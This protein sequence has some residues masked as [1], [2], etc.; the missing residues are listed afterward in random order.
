[1]DQR[2]GKSKAKRAVANDG[3]TD[4]M[5]EDTFADDAPTDH[6]LDDA[7]E[8]LY[9]HEGTTD[10]ML[11][12][13][14]T[15]RVSNESSGEHTLGDDLADT[16]IRTDRIFDSESG[17]DA[18]DSMAE[19]HTLPRARATAP[20]VL[21]EDDFD[22]YAPTV[23]RRAAPVTHESPPASFEN[24]VTLTLHRDFGDA[25]DPVTHRQAPA[26]DE[27]SAPRRIA[28]RRRP[29]SYPPPR[30]RAPSVPALPPPPPPPPRKASLPPIAPPPKKPSLPPPA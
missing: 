14:P 24:T 26:D 3:P 2:R 17:E 12:D 23:E 19:T 1:M 25:P 5:S 6:E 10:R 4:R 13:G 28:A 8:R 30:P 21:T 29:S 7:T 22:D 15:D 16:T 9:P 20:D 18:V 11:D 27:S